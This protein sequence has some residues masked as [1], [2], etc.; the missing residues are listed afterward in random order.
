MTLSCKEHVV[1]CRPR[2]KITTGRDS[3]QRTTYSIHVEGVPLCD[4]S[5]LSAK[6]AWRAASL[7]LYYKLN[8][9]TGLK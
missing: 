1:T 5:T 7:H 8:E 2:A 3:Y 9:R 4:Y 6:E